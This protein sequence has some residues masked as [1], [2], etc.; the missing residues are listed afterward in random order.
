MHDVLDN[1]GEICGVMFTANIRNNQFTD[2]TPAI[3]T[4]IRLPCGDT[5]AAWLPIFTDWF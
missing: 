4:Y 2:G 5:Y 3:K 1:R